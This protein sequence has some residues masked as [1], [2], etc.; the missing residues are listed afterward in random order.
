MPAFSRS[1]LVQ[2]ILLDQRLTVDRAALRTALAASPFDA[3]A[4][5]AIL[6]SISADCV[7]G[8]QWAPIIASWQ[9]S[10]QLGADLRDAYDAIHQEASDALAQSVQLTS[11]YRQSAKAMVSQLAAL[12]AVDDRARALAEANGAGDP[13][14]SAAP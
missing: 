3:S 11:A 9:P 14:T 10:E 2:A 1:A 8:L 7:N 5:A 6:R 12:K 4:V 13:G